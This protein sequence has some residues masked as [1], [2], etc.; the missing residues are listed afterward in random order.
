MEMTGAE[1]TRLKEKGDEALSSVL[2][3]NGFAGSF[4]ATNG[5]ATTDDEDVAPK[6]KMPEPVVPPPEPNG[7]TDAAP[8]PK[9]IPP[10]GPVSAGLS[11]TFTFISLVGLSSIRIP[12]SSPFGGVMGRAGAGAPNAKG[13]I[14]DAGA[15]G[16]LGFVVAPKLKPECEVEVVPKP[17]KESLRSAPDGGVAG[18]A[19]KAKGLLLPVSRPGEA[20][21]DD[22]GGPKVKPTPAADPK[23]GLGAIVSTALDVEGVVV[24]APKVKGDVGLFSVLT[25]DGCDEPKSGLGASTDPPADAEGVEVA[26]EAPKEKKGDGDGTVT[27]LFSTS[28]L[29]SFWSLTWGVNEKNEGV[30]DV[31][32]EDALVAPENKGAFEDEGPVPK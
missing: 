27:G 20:D 28:V 31:V 4:F 9:V 19:P 12:W 16:S 29:A 1:A 32:D 3:A 25:C 7:F 17:G 15:T 11:E 8:D 26:V 6:L 5:F 21:A 23:T 24:G 10:D 2:G 22:G 30:G 13:E 18:A 14:A